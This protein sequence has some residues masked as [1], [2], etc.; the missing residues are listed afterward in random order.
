MSKWYEVLIAGSITALIWMFL[1]LGQQP[2][3]V[4][5]IFSLLGIAILPT[6]YFQI[7]NTKTIRNYKFAEWV[8]DAEK[9]EKTPSWWIFALILNTSVVC[10]VST[11]L[12][13]LYGIIFSFFD[14]KAVSLF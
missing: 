2:A 7:K 11:I 6:T 3:G 4:G 8:D 12:Y 1:K 5:K 9:M 10:L 14:Y 13:F